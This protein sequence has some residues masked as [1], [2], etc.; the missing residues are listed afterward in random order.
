MVSRYVV[1]FAQKLTIWDNYMWKII[2]ILTVF[3]FAALS[4]IFFFFGL[5][6]V[7]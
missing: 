2:F 1:D 7:S 3:A 6:L 4:K 5:S